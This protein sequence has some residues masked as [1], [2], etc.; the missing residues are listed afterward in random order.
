MTT[1]IK[2]NDQTIRVLV[3][4]A[5]EIL[6]EKCKKVLTADCIKNIEIGKRESIKK[7]II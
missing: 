3:K 2:L 5:S 1:L 6:L 7:D 4:G